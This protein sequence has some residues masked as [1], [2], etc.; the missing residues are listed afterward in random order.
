M[1]EIKKLFRH[2]TVDSSI[3]FVSRTRRWYLYLSRPHLRWVKSKKKEKE[4]IALCLHTRNDE[5]NSHENSKNSGTLNSRRQ[6]MRNDGVFHRHPSP[7][8]RRLYFAAFFLDCYFL[9]ALHAT[10]FSR[11]PNAPRNPRSKY[12]RKCMSNVE[13]FRPN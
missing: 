13:E 3:S 7:W 10:L 5:S 12:R 9:V 4:R 8:C 2:S 11:V 1:V 6:K